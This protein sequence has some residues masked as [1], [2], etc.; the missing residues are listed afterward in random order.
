MSTDPLAGHNWPIS[1]SEIEKLFGVSIIETLGDCEPN[2]ASVC[3][4]IIEVGV[5]DVAEYRL[6]AIFHELGHILT[7]QPERQELL[8]I[9]NLAEWKTAVEK[10]AWIHGINAAR[11]LGIA[12]SFSAYRYAVGQIQSYH[13]YN[14]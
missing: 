14:G 1:D 6:F 13:N 9:N 4:N 2:N 7:P 5:Y 10:L 8:E 11:K 12:F 3:G